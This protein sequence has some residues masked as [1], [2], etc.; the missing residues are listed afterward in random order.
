MRKGRLKI[1]A[2]ALL[3]CCFLLPLSLTAAC[4]SGGDD[5]DKPPV[6]TDDND[7]NNN[8]DESNN[9]G[10]NTEE[11]KLADFAYGMSDKFHA[12]NGWTNNGMF[13]CW[14]SN[15]NVVYNQEEKLL[16]LTFSQSEGKHYAGEYRSNQFY[17]YG[18][19]S[20]SMKAVKKPGIVS[21]MFIYTGPSDN[22][23][24]WDEIDIEV[25]GKDTTKV[26]FNYFTNGEG[27]HEYLYDLG[28]DASE[29]FHDYGF[30]WTENSITWFVDGEAV[31]TATKDIPKTP[32][33]FMINAWQGK[34]EEVGNWSGVFDGQ[35]PIEP[36]QYKWMDFKPL[37]E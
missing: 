5:N 32:A 6:I 1:L 26:Q 29:D 3:C 24:P 30:M 27:E 2:S 8:D 28:F 18:Y 25:L 35:Y 4:T 11:E 15:K 10:N 36:A 16:E 33:R 14:W 17:H 31:Y 12:S 19:Y 20:V 23:N 7:D 22:G 34:P 37:G 9:D 13:A 21:S